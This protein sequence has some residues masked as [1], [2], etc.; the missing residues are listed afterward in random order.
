MSKSV[1][2]K[3]IDLRG[4]PRDKQQDIL[5]YAA[6]ENWILVCVS[7]GFAYMKYETTVD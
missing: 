5:N 1:E 2:Y 4:E 6:E 3:V 7:K